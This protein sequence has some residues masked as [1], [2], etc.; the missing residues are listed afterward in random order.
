MRGGC[1]RIRE[2]RE[3]GECME[4]CEGGAHAWGH[5]RNSVFVM[6]HVLKCSC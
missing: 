4:G 2:V 5:G 3:R 6:V 1:E